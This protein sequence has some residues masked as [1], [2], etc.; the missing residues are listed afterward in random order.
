MLREIAYRVFCVTHYLQSVLKGVR[1]GKFH[2][3]TA[4]TSTLSLVS[5]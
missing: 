1:V 5:V 4:L 3:R 2:H